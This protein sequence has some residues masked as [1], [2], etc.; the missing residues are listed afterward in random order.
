MAETS[1]AQGESSSSEPNNS[2]VR[3]LADRSGRT[4]NALE[5]LAK[6]DTFE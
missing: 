6:E 4:S 2:L 1:T 5:R 3:S